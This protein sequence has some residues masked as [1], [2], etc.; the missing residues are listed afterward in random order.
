MLKKH[1]VTEVRGDK[2]RQG[3]ARVPNSE[4]NEYKHGRQNRR[5]H[6]NQSPFDVA[7]A[8]FPVMR[9]RQRV[10]QTQKAR[11]GAPQCQQ[12]PK[13]QKALIASRKTQHECEDHMLRARGQIVG[14]PPGE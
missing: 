14:Q 2:R 8:I 10:H 4:A 3:M 6:G 7:P 13:R 11:R 5:Q 9:L 1:R 12:Q